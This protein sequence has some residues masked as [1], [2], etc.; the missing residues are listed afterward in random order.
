[1][2]PVWRAGWTWAAAAVVALAVGLATFGP[3]APDVARRTATTGGERTAR[4]LQ[5]TPGDPLREGTDDRETS[6]AGPAPESVTVHLDARPDAMDEARFVSL[7]TELLE[8]NRG[9]RREMHALLERVDT[10][11]GPTAESPFAEGGAASDPDDVASAVPPTI[12]RRAE[13]GGGPVAVAN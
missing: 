6:A 4:T 10:A 11:M 13:R 8:S 7:A 1:V 12:E 2:R 9:W 5:T 3:L